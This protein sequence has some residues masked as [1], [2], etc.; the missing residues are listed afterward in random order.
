MPSPTQFGHFTAGAALQSLIQQT[1]FMTAPN[2]H[3]LKS[4]PLIVGVFSVGWLVSSVTHQP[5]SISLGAGATT[6]A[7]QVSSVQWER[8]D[9]IPGTRTELSLNSSTR[10]N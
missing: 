8:Q 4:F 1:C 10:E 2:K 9:E 6:S 5:Y 7:V 3:P